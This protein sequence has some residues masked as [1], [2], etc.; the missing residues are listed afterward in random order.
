MRVLARLED[1][2]AEAVLRAV[3]QNSVPESMRPLDITASLPLFRYGRR[4]GMA[5]TRN[6]C[7]PSSFTVLAC[8]P[9]SPISSANATCVPTARRSYAPSSTLFR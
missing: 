4:S 2:R 8:G 7:F 1:N 6:L 3:K 5:H 9:F